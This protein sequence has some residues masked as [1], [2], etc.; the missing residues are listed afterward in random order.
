MINIMI[1]LDSED[2]ECNPHAKE[3]R[4]L[5]EK[6]YTEALS[7]LVELKAKIDNHVH[8]S[9]YVWSANETKLNGDKQ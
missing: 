6:F 5:Y 8:V 9:K 3:I 1:A 2:L 4:D 7:D